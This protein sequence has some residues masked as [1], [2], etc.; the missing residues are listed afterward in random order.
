MAGDYFS[1]DAS[2]F[3]D[4]KI[5]KLRRKYGLEG[6]GAFWAVVEALRV[7]DGYRMSLQFIQ[8][9]LDDIGAKREIFDYFFECG[10]FEKEDGYFF[11][12]SLFDRMERMTAKGRASRE[13]GKKGGRPPADSDSG[14]GQSGKAA[15]SGKVQDVN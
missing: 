14:N 2:A 15:I 5:A 3:R 12:N 4:P 10:L 9:F 6:Y 13:N 11:S 7:S 8:D 1:H